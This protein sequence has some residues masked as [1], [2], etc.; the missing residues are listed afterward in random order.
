MGSK[1]YG[2]YVRIDGEMTWPHNDTAD[3]ATLIWTLGYGTPSKEQLLHARSIISAY[4]HLIELTQKRR[5]YICSAI[6]ESE[7]P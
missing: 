3:I 6:R 5:N 1:K 2:N 7:K 4:G